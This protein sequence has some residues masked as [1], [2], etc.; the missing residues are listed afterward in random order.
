MITDS[1]SIHVQRNLK[2]KVKYALQDIANLLG[3]P[4]R[5]L[6]ALSLEAFGTSMHKPK[7]VK[8]YRL[9]S[10]IT[11]NNLDRYGAASSFFTRLRIAALGHFRLVTCLKS[12]SLTGAQLTDC[13]HIPSKMVLG[14]VICYQ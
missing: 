9:P 10:C 3:Y 2:S 8:L 11:S 7:H 5:S 6:K 1:N 4:Q 12:L 13:L 14:Q